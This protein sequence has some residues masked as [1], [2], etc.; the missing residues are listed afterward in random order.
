MK[1]NLEK[2]FKASLEN[3]EMPYDAGAWENVKNQL[4]GSKLSALTKTGIA[5]GII[6]IVSLI[7]FFALPDQQSAK[8]TVQQ[9]S[10]ATPAETIEKVTENTQ[11]P[12]LKPTEESVT[13]VQVDSSSETDSP[14]S[15]QTESRRTQLSPIRGK[16]IDQETQNDPVNSGT[17]S[18]HTTG[19]SLNSVDTWT[20]L[21]DNAYIQLSEKTICKG[22]EITAIVK[23]VP[24]NTLI[25]WK[26]GQLLATNTSKIT[27]TPE[28]SVLIEVLLTNKDNTDKKVLQSTQAIVKESKKTVVRLTEE[29]KNT[30]PYFI[31]ENQNHEIKDISWTMEYSHASGNI[32]ELYMT[33]KGRY[34]YTIEG[35]DMNN[36]PVKHEGEIEVR[37]DY[38]LLAPSGFSPNGDGLND[39]FIPKA[40][41]TREVEFKMSIFDRSG[42]LVYQT[43]D[44]YSSWDGTTLNGERAKLGNNFVWV[45]TLINEEGLPEKYSGNIVIVK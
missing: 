17:G 15:E 11:K 41:L 5:A 18:D 12:N 37:E 22:S 9:P 30:K 42:G 13:V 4:P 35:R 6:A 7:T 20:P 8:Q 26:A 25:E 40:L 19:T 43:T 27:L 16:S 21:A 3:H 36:C 33:E 38:N 29:I 44:K 28:E 10:Q 39:R 24:E 2:I 32:L 14:L 34:T 1:Q 31:L 23:N 45:V